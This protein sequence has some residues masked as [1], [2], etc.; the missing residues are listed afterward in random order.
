M[1]A[2]AQKVKENLKEKQA[3]KKLVMKLGPM[4][5]KKP[6]LRRDFLLSHPSL[7]NPP[8]LM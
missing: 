6:Y 4:V 7:T 3:A 8:K 5:G 1:K 2:A